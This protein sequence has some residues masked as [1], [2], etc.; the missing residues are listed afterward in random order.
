[1]APS[2]ASQIAVAVLTALGERQG[3]TAWNRGPSPAA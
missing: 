1:M 3:R 2:A